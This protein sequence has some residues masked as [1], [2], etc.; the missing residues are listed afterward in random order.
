MKVTLLG[1]GCPQCSTKRMG[2]ANLLEHNGKS[3]L[4]DC[5]SGVTQRLL[6]AGSSSAAID[7]VLLTH[8]HSD[9]IIDLYQLIQTAWHQGRDRP[10]RFF[11]PKGTRKYLTGLMALWKEEREMRIAHEQRPSVAALDL[12]ITEIESDGPFLDLDGLRISAVTVEHAPVKSAFGFVFEAEEDGV[13]QK[14]AF[15][16]DTRY[17][18]ALIEASKGADILVH[19][20]FV[21]R[22]L[23]VIEGVRSAETLAAMAAYHTVSDEVGQ[24]AREAE[25]KFLL[26]NH[27]VPV[28][29]D[30][31]AVA[32]DVSADF[33]GPFAIGEDLMSYD[34][35]SCSLSHA[36]GL[37]VMARE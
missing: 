12:E 9:H 24:V 18:K 10:Q 32:A 16:G 19:E 20:C 2:P 17:C 28:D 35:P 5:G 27:F 1:T 25:V 23:P 30:R 36:E 37:A 22:E 33:K 11:G 6:G 7:A 31:Q 8:L 21:H 13:Q 34:I 26:L 29:F 3:V 15:S 4:V 14:A